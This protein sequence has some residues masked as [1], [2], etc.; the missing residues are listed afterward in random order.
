MVSKL[1]IMISEPQ[2]ASRFFCSAGFTEIVPQTGRLWQTVAEPND[3][4]SPLIPRFYQH[5]Y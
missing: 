4:W 2:T 5:R 1:E 3:N